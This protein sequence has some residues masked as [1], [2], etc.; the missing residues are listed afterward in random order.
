MAIVAQVY[1]DSAGEADHDRFQLAVY[2]RMVE[3]GVS[4]EGLM[5]HVGYPQNNG[6]TM[7]EV[8]RTEALFRES[9]EAVGRPVL[10][11]VGLVPSEPV[12]SPAWSFMRPDLS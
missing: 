4:F 7:V 11:E 9:F 3:L 5:S 10:D 1:I 8:W 12:I 6:I 2:E